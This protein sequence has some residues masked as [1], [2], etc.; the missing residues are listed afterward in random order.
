VRG[1]REAKEWKRKLDAVMVLQ[2]CLRMSRG[3]MIVKE[4]MKESATG[5]LRVGMESMVGEGA[6]EEYEILVGLLEKCK[7]R[8][9][10]EDDEAYK[11][12][13]ER[14]E[15]MEMQFSALEALVVVC[16]GG[17]ME[18]IKE[19]IQSVEDLGCGVG[20]ERLVRGYRKLQD[21][22]IEDAVKKVEVAVGDGN[23]G[24][25]VG[26]LIEVRGRLGQSDSKSIK[27]PPYSDERRKSRKGL[28]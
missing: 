26:G 25:V 6:E 16:L 2:S 24:K 3:K 13:L 5:D 7:A 28:G 19:A 4:K 20:D 12:G 8:G 10:G 17:D 22:E 23:E 14:K 11:K 15:N 1:R 18:K 9:V 27:P 21:L